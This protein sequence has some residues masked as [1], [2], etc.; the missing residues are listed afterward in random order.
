MLVQAAVEGNL[1]TRAD[2][3][4]HQGEFRKIVQGINDT[5]DAVTGPLRIAAEYIK[6]LSE[7]DI[8]PK[9]TASYKGEFN[10][11]INN[12]NHYAGCSKQD[13]SKFSIKSPRGI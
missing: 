8:M 7:G 5:L 1:A 12:L 10:E 13:E 4:K 6:H 2:A 11:I 9:I 3:S